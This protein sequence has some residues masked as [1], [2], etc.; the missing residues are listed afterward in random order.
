M[1]VVKEY[2]DV[3]NPVLILLEIITVH[4]SLDLNLIMITTPALV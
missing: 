4:V 3:L 2:L 1:N